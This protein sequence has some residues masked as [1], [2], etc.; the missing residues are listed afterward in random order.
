M[1]F[2]IEWY[3][4]ERSDP[5]GFGQDTIEP[6]GTKDKSKIKFKHYSLSKIQFIVRWFILT[7][8][9]FARDELYWIY[10]D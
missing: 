4:T 10:F 3:C 6:C 2:P 5:T 8:H 9:F 7:Y 1:I